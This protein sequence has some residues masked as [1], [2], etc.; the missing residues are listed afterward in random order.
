MQFNKYT[1]AQT[2]NRRMF[3][4]TSGREQKCASQLSPS[5]VITTVLILWYLFVFIRFVCLS[6]FL[7]R[8]VPQGTVCRLFCNFKYK[9]I[10]Q[11]TTTSPLLKG[12]CVTAVFVASSFFFFFYFEAHVRSL[13]HCRKL[14]KQRVTSTK[15]QGTNASTTP[16]GT[17][18]NTTPQGTNPSTYKKVQTPTPHHKVQTPAPTK[19]Y[20]HQHTTRYKHQHLQKGTNTSTTKRCKHQHHKKV[21][22]PAPQ[23]RYKHQHHKKVQT[24]A[25]Q[26]D[27]NTT[28]TKR[29]KHHHHKKVQTPVQHKRFKHQHHTKGTNT[30]THTKDTHK[31]PKSLVEQ[32]NPSTK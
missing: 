24:P 18:T 3:V 30:S 13:L 12:Y 29:Y 22:T 14:Y 5:F 16:Q 32:G 31:N 15:P 1:H 4:Q 17:N 20:K 6:I 11:D 23:K 10:Q 27:T 21:Q 9:S 28:A 25:P 7:A 2:H 8:H 26:K 19:K